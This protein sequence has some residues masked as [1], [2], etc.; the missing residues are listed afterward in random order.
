LFASR[1]A[2]LAHSEN[3]LMLILAYMSQTTFG[4]KQLMLYKEEEMLQIWK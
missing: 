1:N 4:A 2:Y 3:F